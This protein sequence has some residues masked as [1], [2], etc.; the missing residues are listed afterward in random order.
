MTLT[1]TRVQAPKCYW[2]ENFIKGLQNCSYLILEM[3]LKFLD[4]DDKSSARVHS[5]LEQVLTAH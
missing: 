5:P 4:L 1:Y 2:G 3:K